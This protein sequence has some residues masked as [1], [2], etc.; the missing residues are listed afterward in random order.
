MEIVNNCSVFEPWFRWRDWRRHQTVAGAAVGTDRNGVAIQRD[1]LRQGSNLG[2]R[3][4]T[5]DRLCATTQ[6]KIEFFGPNAY[7]DAN[8]RG[9]G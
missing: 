7:C 5:N 4:R 6:R 2:L 8:S 3:H 9:R 1:R